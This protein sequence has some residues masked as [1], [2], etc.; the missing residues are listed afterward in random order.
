MSAFEGKI[1]GT[2]PRTPFPIVHDSDETNW[3]YTERR[4]DEI[5]NAVCRIPGPIHTLSIKITGIIWAREG[6]A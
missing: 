3:Q 2:L 4:S 5:I 1:T 6:I